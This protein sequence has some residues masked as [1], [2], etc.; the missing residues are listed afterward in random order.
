MDAEDGA[1]AGSGHGLTVSDG[2]VIDHYPDEQLEQR[3]G[4]PDQY[5]LPVGAQFY[6]G[7]GRDLTDEDGEIGRFTV[8]SNDPDEPRTQ[9]TVWV[10]RPTAETGASSGDLS[11]VSWHGERIHLEEFRGKVIF[12]KL[13]NSL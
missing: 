5:L 4:C 8:E 1:E 11:L 6:V 9:S 7:F 2:F 12:I 3:P 13:A 10:N